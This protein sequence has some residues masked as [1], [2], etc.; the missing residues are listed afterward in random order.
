MQYVSVSGSWWSIQRNSLTKTDHILL[1]RVQ[2]EIRTVIVTK[3]K[4]DIYPWSAVTQ[5]FSNGQPSND[6][7]CKT[8]EIIG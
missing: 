6:N 1:Y 3:T 8:F 7:D 5:I 2:Y 4:L